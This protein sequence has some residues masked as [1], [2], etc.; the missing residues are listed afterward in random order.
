MTV[1]HSFFPLIQFVKGNDTEAVPS[2]TNTETKTVFILL[3]THET[4]SSLISDREQTFFWTALFQT[5]SESDCTL[6]RQ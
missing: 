4:G 5:P 6:D 3:E 1:V 2:V